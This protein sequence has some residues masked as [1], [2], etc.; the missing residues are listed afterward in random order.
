MF[1][2]SGNVVAQLRQVKFIE[3]AVF[4]GPAKTTSPL[5]VRAVRVE[6]TNA[7]GFY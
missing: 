7:E 3:L 2:V 6:L 1:S 5:V 4:H